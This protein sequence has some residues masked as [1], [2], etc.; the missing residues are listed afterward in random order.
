M[1]DELEVPAWK[2]FPAQ[3]PFLESGARE[4]LYGGAA[5]GGKTDALVIGALRHVDHPKYNGI[6]FRRTFPELEGKVIPV[7]REWYPFAGGKYNGSTHVWTFPS[8]ARI[9]LAHLQHESDVEIYQGHEF[10]YIG[11][12][13]LTHFTERQYTYLLSRLRTSSGLPLFV[14]S[15]TNPGS[16]GH[17]WVFR[18]WA[19]W[20]DTTPDYEGP[21][22]APGQ[23]LR[24]NNTENGEAWCDT[25]RFSRVFFPA[26]ATDNPY[27][28]DDYTDNLMGLDVVTREQLIKG[29]WL[30]KPAPG[31]LFRRAMF[32]LLDAVPIDVRRRVRFWD[33]AATEETENGE[34]K[35]DPDW[36]VGVRMSRLASGLFC[37]ENAVRLRA[38]PAEVEKTIKN[39]A[40][41]DPPGTEIHLS[42]DP[43]SAG[44]FE[45]KYYIAA[46]AG[47]IVKAA[48]E[49][50]DKVS[51]AQPFSAQCEAG[52]VSMV[53]GPWNEAYL[54]IL[55]AFPTKGVHDDDVDASS[56]AF[57]VL[58][59]PIAGFGDSQWHSPKR[60]F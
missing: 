16:V 53:R 39:T 13:E 35:K 21:R 38:S 18:R 43:G 14:R 24:F 33:R 5:G 37:I 60:Q 11:F 56:G 58:S 20:L 49:S 36:T 40:E 51:R 25:G 42:Q 27:L 47:H 4:A 52:N 23:V 17:E 50:G 9:A 6:I 1:Q 2:P 31:L 41:I 10:Q 15:G 12:D 29:N 34:K 45:A 19:P 26:Y 48:P 7:T 57:S 54:Q 8:G 22:A 28:N 46:L 32:R 30:I 55:E 44:K 3:V 59:K